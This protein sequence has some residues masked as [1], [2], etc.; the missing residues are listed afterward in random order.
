MPSCSGSPSEAQTKSFSR[1]G[2]P[3]KGPLGISARMACARAFS[4]S[5][6]ITAL[7]Y[8]LTFSIRAIAASTSSTGFT[9][10]FR[11]NSAWAIPSRNASSVAIPGSSS[12]CWLLGAY[13]SLYQHVY[14]ALNVFPFPAFQRQFANL[15]LE[16]LTMQAHLRRGAGNVPLVAAKGTT[17]EIALEGFD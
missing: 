9:S 8:G 2:T 3:R 1:N 6:V 11:T 16:L 17:N 4:K 12:R 10:P 5:G 14:P 7:S 13:T 15:L